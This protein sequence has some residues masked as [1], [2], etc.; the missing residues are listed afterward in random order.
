MTSTSTGAPPR[1]NHGPSPADVRTFVNRT[2]ELGQLNA[3]VADRNREQVV[4]S[5]HGV[6][7]TAGAG[8]TSLVLHWA[9]QVKGQFPDGQLFVTLRAYHPGE[10]VTAR[11]ALH[12]FLR[13]LGVAASEVPEDVEAAAAMYRSLLADRRILILLDHAAAVSQVR[14]LLP[15]EA[16]ASS[17]SPVAVAWRVCPYGTAPEE[18]PS[19][20]CRNRRRSP[21]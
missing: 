11:Q 12:R 16:T 5:I 4:L 13:A 18:S 6:A 3:V 14:P 20:H 1:R 17:W 2:H 8:K 15:A 9:H 19:A 21:C 10:P 7:G